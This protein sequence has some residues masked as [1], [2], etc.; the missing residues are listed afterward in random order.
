MLEFEP[1]STKTNI[2]EAL[3]YFSNTI[4]KRSIGFVISDFIDR[5]DFSSSLK[6]AGKKH[7]LVA[8]KIYDQREMELP[9]VGLVK[10][11]DPET[12][13]ELWVNT[14]KKQTRTTYRAIALKKED[15]IQMIFKKAGVDFAN[16]STDQD[17]IKPLMTLFKRREQYG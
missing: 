17:Y 16:I 2:S 7:D 14:S 8:L 11:N 6:I 13:E 12:N 15:E 1:Q 4:K 10:F 9:N 5:E 3:R